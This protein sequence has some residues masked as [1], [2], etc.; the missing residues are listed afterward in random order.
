MT[1]EQLRKTLWLV[2]IV[3]WLS[4]F[5]QSIENLISPKEQKNHL[6]KADRYIK[7]LQRKLS[8]Q[9]KD[10]NRRARTKHRIAVHHAK[11]AN[12][13]KDFAHKLAMHW[14]MDLVKF[15]I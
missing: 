5:M 7:R 4:L 2:L 12:I 11:K 15:C 1:A 6:S 10:S 13:R 8:Q 14:L 9:Q 3:A